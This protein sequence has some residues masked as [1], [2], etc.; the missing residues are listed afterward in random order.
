MYQEKEILPGQ[1]IIPASRNAGGVEK[2]TNFFIGN[3][4]RQVTSAD[5]YKKGVSLKNKIRLNPMLF[6]H[7]Q[8]CER[9]KENSERKYD[10]PV[11]KKNYVTISI[12]FPKSKI[13]SEEKEYMI[14]SVAQQQELSFLSAEDEE[15]L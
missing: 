11:F 8:K 10:M 2:G 15:Q 1:L 12:D 13:K 7:I 4:S 3:E 5:V 6:I 9:I 14:N